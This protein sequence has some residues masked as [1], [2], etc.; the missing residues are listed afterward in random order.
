MFI[1]HQLFMYHFVH[2]RVYFIQVN[3]I[4]HIFKFDQISEQSLFAVV[5]VEKHGTWAENYK[6]WKIQKFLEMQV[7]LS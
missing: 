2:F 5:F 1:E 6:C 3:S 4:E 7:Q